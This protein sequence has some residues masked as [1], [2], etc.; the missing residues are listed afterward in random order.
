MAD[1][2]AQAPAPLRANQELS[3]KP[4]HASSLAEAEA[5]H[6]RKV[7][8]FFSRRRMLGPVVKEYGDYGL[9]ATSFVTGMVDGAS[10]LN[11]GV[12]VGMQTGK[13]LQGIDR[14]LGSFVGSCVSCSYT[15]I[16]IYIVTRL[17]MVDVVMK[18]YTNN[19]TGNTVILGLST[20][21]LPDMPHAWLA[22]LVSIITFLLGAMATFH[23]S[24]YLTPNGVTSNRLWTS[25]LFTLQGLFIFIAAALATPD[26]LIPQ[27]PAG[28]SFHTPEPTW[29]KH[30]IRIV[31]LL[32]LLGWQAGMQIAASRLLGFNE[33]PVNVVTSTY[34]DL[35]GD[36]K[37]L[38]TNNVKRNRR[39]ASVIL[40]FIGSITS[41]W[42]M[43]SRGGLESVLWVAGAIKVLAGLGLFIWLPALREKEL[44]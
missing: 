2:T 3:E 38:A 26:N 44:P 7:G 17:R 23:V 37:L 14:R 27:N 40:L 35:M 4:S 21:G 41:A 24:K 28:T 1:G 16:H 34:C 43:R 19:D 8:G 6:A 36:F 32:P 42:L 15:C 29:V 39:A 9:L 5:P 13:L 18:S 10:F 11:W 20:A 25:S 12:F 31:S 22:T 30:D 33:L